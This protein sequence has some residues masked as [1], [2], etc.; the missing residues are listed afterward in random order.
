LLSGGRKG[1]TL[2]LWNVPS[3]RLLRT[4][5][6]EHSDGIV[7]VAF[8]PNGK[9][10][11]SSGKDAKIKLWD[12]ASG[13]LIRT[14]SEDDD[15]FVA[16]AFS[17][18]GRHLLSATREDRLK[19][20][21]AVSARLV[22]TLGTRTGG[23]DIAQALAT[24]LPAGGHLLSA[25]NEPWVWDESSGKLIRLWDSVEGKLI[26][27]LEGQDRS[28]RVDAVALS[29]DRKR[30]LAGSGNTVRL[31][32]TISGR[33]I[34]TFKDHSEPVSSVA[35]SPDGKRLLSGSHAPDATLKL[36]D[37]T[38][39]DLI[40]TIQG[41]VAPVISAAL[42][43][44][45][46]RLLTGSADNTVRLWDA[47][48]GE[49]IRAIA[50]HSRP[51]TSVA[52]SP[53]GKRLLSGSRD[54]TLKLW[55]AFSGR[56]IFEGQ[57]T[58]EEHGSVGAVAFSRDGTRLYSGGYGKLTLWHATSGQRIRTFKDKDTDFGVL[59]ISPDG[60]H[61]TSYSSGDSLKLLDADNGRVIRTLALGDL[62][63]PSSVAFSP[64]GKRLLAAGLDMLRLWDL[65][66]GKL[67]RTFHGG[68]ENFIGATIS[69]FEGAGS[70]AFSSDGR[71]LL[72]GSEYAVKL[73]DAATGRLLRTFEGHSGHVF[74]VALL[75]DRK[76]LISGSEDGTIRIWNVESGAV[77]ATLLAAR[78]GEW[79]A[80]T[81]EGFFA[82]SP[83]GHELL[84]IVRGLD[85]FSID[86][87]YEALYRPDLVR[88]KLAGDPDGKVKA[89]AAKLDLAK[90]LDSGPV[91]KVAI[92][93]HTVDKSSP[94]LVTVEAR[95]VDGG[96]GIGKAEWRISTKETAG[97]KKIIPVSELATGLKQRIALDPGENLIELVAYNGR[98]L[99]SSVPASIKV[100]WDGVSDYTAPPKLFV[101][102]IGINEY[103]D[104]K[105][106][107]D[108]AVPDAREMVRVLQVAGKGRYEE[109]VTR[110]VTDEEA[111]A[112]GIGRVVDELAPKVRPRDVL[113]LYVAAH[114][115]V[116]TDPLTNAP[117][118]Y[119]I[120]HDL[121]YEG[122]ESYA[123][124]GIDQDR[125]LKWVDKLGANK[126]LLIFDTCESAQLTKLQ[127]ASRG[128]SEYHTA[129]DHLIRATGRITL[130]AESANKAA[131][132][133][134][135]DHGVLTFAVLD[136]LARGDK[137]GDGL[138]DVTELIQHVSPLVPEISK[139]LG[140]LQ[141]PRSSGSYVNFP[142]VRQ[143][144]GL[145]PK[146]PDGAP[147]IIPS[148]TTHYTKELLQVF[149][150]AGGGA[151]AKELPPNF[152]VTVVRSENGWVLIA[153]D[154]KAIGYVAEG[155]VPSKLQ[156]LD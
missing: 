47:A 29:P 16:V 135:G 84:S 43:S 117:R 148:K 140:A 99:V 138:V 15:G 155:V 76:R 58:T 4:I 124:Q 90:L 144:P 51:V 102:A 150:E 112:A 75:P 141:V 28:E 10:L 72:S 63:S 131:R 40:R 136:A 8:S 100:R 80:L 69:I 79:L 81:P 139:R 36:W 114:G 38:S 110:L 73:W 45:G 41:E 113:V 24:L 123:K 37:A 93:S 95:L 55:D 147:V 91:P 92:T 132:E 48:S 9:L 115:K 101:L 50:G 66:S 19:I 149:K 98:K 105:W 125:I 120:P 156:K 39:G 20:W 35:F 142:L 21:D 18:D 96:S 82:A 128:G 121:K 111:T 5:N 62:A 122:E 14:F 65:G 23:A 87:F 97:V 146:A 85:V 154:G 68:N 106:K 32:D 103:W 17:S 130:V 89:A 94:D 126:S 49:L 12:A 34:R 127:V 108:F 86:Q 61:L 3:G 151:I 78:D 77:L 26:P 56:L 22:R 71:R 54:K 118:Y 70:V 59:A 57:H 145:A 52:V 83:R 6:S 107:L 116:H 53:D 109:V 42:S 64:D 119:L 30:L 152:G 11:L 46:T 88:E 25:D 67:L 104:S 31:W 27:A 134:W 74:S 60:R 133:G 7:W 153:R 143:V 13:R 129:I 1:A 137:G 44:D 33:L 2:Y